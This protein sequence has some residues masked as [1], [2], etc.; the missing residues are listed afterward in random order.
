M[1]F[2]LK[3]GVKLDTSTIQSQ[4]D[5]AGYKAKL[6]V[7]TQLADGSLKET[8]KYANNLGK[9]FTTV[10]GQI[11]S[12]ST[13]MQS[14]STRVG[15]LGKD[16]V[17]TTGKVLKFGASTAIIG[18]FTAGV[19]EANQSVKEMDASLI[20]LRKVTDLSGDG[21]KNFTQDAFDMAR[22]LH[23]TASNVTDAVTEF[24]KSGYNIEESKALAESAL[25][26][27]TIADDAIS[28][29]DSATM[30]IQVMKAYNMTA[31]QSMHITNA[32]NEV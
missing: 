16:F 28:A 21:L 11:K 9:G 4:L 18:L 27:Q 30:L 13:N 29:S 12:I 25:V 31:E 26:F 5:K 3:T 20:E 22:E 19:A 14:A 2:I 1:S 23:T 32:I 8:I 15:Q 7:E 10:N 24:S 17:E 6:K